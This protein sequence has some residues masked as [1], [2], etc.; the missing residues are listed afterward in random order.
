LIEGLKDGAPFLD[1]LCKAHQV[2]K[3][4]VVLKV[5]KSERGAITTMAHTSRMAGSAEIYEAAFRQFGVIS[6]DTVEAFLGAAQMAA[7]QPPPQSGKLMVL[8][9]TG[10]GASLMADKAKEYG[11]ELAD[12]SEETRARIPSRRSAILANPFDTAG[13]SRSPRFLPTVCDAFASDLANDCLLLLLGPLAVRH[14]Y[15]VSFCE[16]VKR[17]RKAAAA[18]V[19]LTEEEMEEVFRQHHIPLFDSSTDAC[20]RVLRGFI[21]YGQFCARQQAGL[22]ERDHPPQ[23]RSSVDRMLNTCERFPMMPDSTTRE[24]LGEYGLRTPSYAVASSYDVAREAAGKIRFPVI[25]KGITPNLA[26]KNEAGVVSR[27]ISDETE[28]KRE[29]DSIHQKAR[30][31]AGGLEPV[32]VIVEKYIAHDYEVIIGVKYDAVFGPVVLFGLGGVF[33]EVLRD[34]SLRLAPLTTT[35]ALD[36]LS[37]LKAFPV[38]ERAASQG[39]VDLNL[40]ADAIVKVS[41][42]AVDL[43]GRM[44]ALDINPI[45]LLSVPP[46]IM[47][48]DAKIHL[49]CPGGDGRSL[50]AGDDP[51]AGDNVNNQLAFRR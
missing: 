5:G 23:F 18:I 28:L 33:T 14:Q 12:I 39:V 10:A 43:N 11:I 40:L 16:A 21:Q 24:L 17:Y 42:L 36:M 45:A 7:N 4:V 30:A 15:A 41:D 1:L 46:G 51:R 19:S 49:L 26:H 31:L 22:R 27:R 25:L 3:A 2:G 37:D 29:Y 38:F 48:L 8:T 32:E 50:S 6:T 34:Y 20:F 13:Q 9:S 47:V 35:E 44:A